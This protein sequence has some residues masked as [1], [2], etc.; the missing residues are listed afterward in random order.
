MET[1]KQT[2]VVDAI[3]RGIVRLVATSPAG[4]NLFLIGGFRYRFM[5]HSVRT[6]RD[7]DYH[8]AGDLEEKQKQLLTLFRKRLI[9]LLRRQFGYEADVYAATGPDSD[10]HAVKTVVLA[11]WKTDSESGR[12]EIPVEIT[13]IVCAD[14]AEIRT[15]DGVVYPTLSDA[16]LIES[17]IMA[18]FNRT[19]LEHR[20]LVDI[21]LFGNR[22]TVDAPRRM[23]RKLK[24]L[25]IP[26]L[27]IKTRLDDLKKHASYHTKAVQT[28][29]AAQL[30]PEAAENINSAG[31]AA[32]VLAKAVKTIRNNVGVK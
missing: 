9:P 22:F 19:I 24:S 7:I 29:I 16:D 18:V 28:V 27:R 23:K 25:K 10:S 8:W 14:K 32:S 4:H 13:R 12:I 2:E 15:V 6:S 17:K 20:D 21:F 3:Q 5:D 31:G 11:V 26:A 30:D 1:E